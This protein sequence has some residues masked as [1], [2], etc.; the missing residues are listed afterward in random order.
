MSRSPPAQSKAELPPSKA[1]LDT[2]NLTFL[3]KEKQ[4]DDDK[5]IPHPR[6]PGIPGLDSSFSL[7]QPSRSDCLRYS[8]FETTSRADVG[9]V[10]HV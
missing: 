9:I 5:V 10:K 6:L 1:F 4:N 7:H 2:A 3:K 8:H